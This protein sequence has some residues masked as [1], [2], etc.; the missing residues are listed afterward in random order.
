[1]YI[2]DQGNMRIRKVDTNGIVTTFAGSTGGF[3]DGVG[4]AAQF[5]FYGGTTTGTGRRSGCIE[6]SRDG[7]SLYVADSGNHRIR[8]IDIA[9]REV[10]TIAGTGA[11][12]Y[13]GDN[14]PALAAEL[15]DPGDVACSASGDIYFSDRSNHVVRKIDAAGIITT[16]AGS[17]TQGASPSGTPALQAKL[18]NPLG[19]TFVYATSTLYIADMY[20]H[21]VKKVILP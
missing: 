20:N 1:M 8:K 6:I 16:V 5:G 17:G 15:N 19:I 9:T 14:G 4:E 11:A 18:A 21:Q 10:T 3:A 12:G 7:A 2:T 13:S